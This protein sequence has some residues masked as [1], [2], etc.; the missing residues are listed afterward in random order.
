VEGVQIAS[1]L[2]CCTAGALACALVP[3]NLF[4]AFIWNEENNGTGYQPA[5][6]LNNP[7]NGAKTC[8][9]PNSR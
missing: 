7:S 3:G 5:R 6:Y 9:E 8:P 2:G 4:R 1:R